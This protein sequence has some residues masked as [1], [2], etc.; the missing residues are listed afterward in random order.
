[1][2]PGVKV[3][4]AGETYVVPELNFQGLQE[5]S[6]LMKEMHQLY[7]FPAEDLKKKIDLATAAH[8]LP[9]VHAAIK[10][11]YP[12]VSLEKLRDSLGMSDLRSGEYFKALVA[13]MNPEGDKPKL[14]EEPAV[15]N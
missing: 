12:E 10:R 9:L 13:A 1:M 8:F 14:G 6:E 7:F 5:N 11:N 4:L 2:L 3:N 15:V